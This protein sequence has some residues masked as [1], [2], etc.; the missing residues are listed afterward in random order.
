MVVF[1]E[2]GKECRGIPVSGVGSRDS[3][4]SKVVVGAPEFSAA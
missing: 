1:V 4:A 3:R 2:F